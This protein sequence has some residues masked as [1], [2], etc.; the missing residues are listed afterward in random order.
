MDVIDRYVRLKRSGAN[1]VACC[2]FHAEKTPSF[3]VSPGK[4]FYYCF[5]C[6]AHGSAIGF[7]MAHCGLGFV[8][9]VHEL[10]NRVGMNVPQQNSEVANHGTDTAALL[11]MMVR[12]TKF[13]R[14]Q[15]KSSPRAIEYLKTRGLT[16]EIAARFGIGYAP[17]GWHGLDESFG[18]ACSDTL[19]RCGLVI[20]NESGRRYDRFRDRIMFPILDARAN[21]I[22]FG[23]RVIGEGEPKYLNSP[24]TPLF[25]K[26]RELYGLP[27]ARRA[28]RE[29]DSVVVVEGYMDVVA[30]AQHGVENAVAT[31]GT[32]TTPAHV[33][34]LLRQARQV[35]FCFD[36]DAAGR[37]AAWRALESSLEHLVDDRTVA[38]LFLPQDHDPDSYVRKLGAP[39]FR[40]LAAE[41]VP[42]SDF[43]VRE[44]KSRTDPVSAEGRSRL[45]AD[46]KPLIARIQAPLL[47]AQLVRMLA[48]LGRVAPAEL[49]SLFG[50]KPL[51]R[52]DRT[53]AAA[54]RRNT[55]LTRRVLRIVLQKPE[56]SACIPVE[57]LPVGDPE[58]DALRTIT[59]AFDHGELPA[60]R[61]DMVVEYFRGG[62]H[63]SL[64]DAV[65]RE[66]EGERT[67]EGSME[68][69]F[70]DAMDRLRRHGLSREIAALN[71]KEKV[72]GLSADE[73][74]QL[75]Q[76]LM[77][78]QKLASLGAKGQPH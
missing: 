57:L 74:R 33:H 17:D 49:E 15:L 12:A 29:T 64:L 21:V 76:L 26:G 50:L 8:D 65:Y 54:P 62:P 77:Q 9:A 52:R 11:D 18:P 47:R 35:V 73:R 68:A 23:G 38:F 70:V 60:G 69:V 41:A 72:A 32:A 31:L 66:L 6:G 28:I 63:E 42:L 51:A 53:S 61:L 67:D 7:I 39:A 58:A 59:H 43:L 1:Y 3:T 78:K 46:A 44:L 20:E 45:L 36:G 14:E 16:G 56:W 75:A 40:Q 37:K 55:S 19:H 13:Y 10:A 27:Q 4:Q 22:G 71:E 34:K 5:G 30:L 24:E 48:E 2:P 25:E